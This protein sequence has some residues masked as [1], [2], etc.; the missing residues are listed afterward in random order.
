MNNLLAHVKHNYAVVL[1][2]N[3]GMVDPFDDWTADASQLVT[4]AMACRDAGLEGIFFD[5][6]EYQRSHVAVSERLQIRQQQDCNAIS[7]AVASTRHAGDASDHRAMAT[8]QNPRNDWAKS[9]GYS[10]S[11]RSECL[12]ATRTG[13]AVTS[14]WVC[15]P[16]R[17]SA[18]MSFLVANF[19]TTEPLPSF[20][21]GKISST[22]R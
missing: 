11:S 14:S 16:E 17:Q 20:Q 13:W 15:L 10:G 1:I 2:G 21:T 3:S 22:P 4:L 5:N 7:R 9:V 19:T 18:I 6:E 8:S 12:T